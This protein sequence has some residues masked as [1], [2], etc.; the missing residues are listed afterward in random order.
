MIR[1]SGFRTNKIIG[2][3]I[4]SWLKD[5]GVRPQEAPRYIVGGKQRVKAEMALAV[6]GKCE[7][8]VKNR[9]NKN[10]T[11]LEKDQNKLK[12]SEVII[13]EEEA[14]TLSEWWASTTARILDALTKEE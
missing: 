2:K 13:V 5:R 3:L 12:L 1:T 9:R 10:L 4:L 11:R 8:E 7:K 6:K 14:K